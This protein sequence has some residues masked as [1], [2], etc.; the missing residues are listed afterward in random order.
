MTDA[1]KITNLKVDYEPGS[2]GC[3]G[4]LEIHADTPLG[5]F[6]YNRELPMELQMDDG[7][8][9]TATLDGI[10][11][12]EEQDE[13]DDAPELPDF[14]PPATAGRGAKLYAKEAKK[15][16]TEVLTAWLENRIARAKK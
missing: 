1:P 8:E 12:V 11:L 16:V 2:S 15:I 6:D 10:D 4:Y 7:L 3:N 9:L 5:E 14:D 13:D